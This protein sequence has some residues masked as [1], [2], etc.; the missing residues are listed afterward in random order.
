MGYGQYYQTHEGNWISADG[1]AETCPLLE[2]QHAV[3][4]LLF[5]PNKGIWS[6][7]SSPWQ[8]TEPASHLSREILQVP[9]F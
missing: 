2:H 1:Q 5:Y 6:T 4:Q 7:N 3:L 8:R 9:A